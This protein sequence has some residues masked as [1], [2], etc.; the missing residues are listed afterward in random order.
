MLHA[1]H[2]RPSVPRGQ[3]NKLCQPYET[4]RSLLLIDLCHSEMARDDSAFPY[5][6]RIGCVDATDF[7]HCSLL[8]DG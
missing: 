8:V 6:P 3:E 1:Q 5:G 2:I 7:H 4:D